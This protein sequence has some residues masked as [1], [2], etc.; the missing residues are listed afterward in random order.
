M[1]KTVQVICLLSA[2]FNKTGLASQ[3][4]RATQD[5][6]DGFLKRKKAK[7]AREKLGLAGSDDEEED[8][9][10]KKAKHNLKLMKEM[11]ILEND[12]SQSQSQEVTQSQTEKEEKDSFDVDA[13]SRSDKKPS[14][15]VQPVLIVVPKT[16]RDSWRT[17]LEQW[18][19]FSVLVVTEKESV[20][21]GAARIAGAKEGK[22]EVVVAAYSM[23]S[24]VLASSSLFFP[25]LHAFPS[26]FP[27]S[28]DSPSLLT[29][30]PLPLCS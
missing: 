23:V 9:K 4:K 6:L 18:G 27:F 29:S 14:P 22:Y 21:V 19:C 25:P 1:G 26:S 7:K 13:D 11:G 12:D 3:D 10:V 17:H 15:V 28:L 8:P 2:M 24:A 5:R 20:E 16:V 30:S